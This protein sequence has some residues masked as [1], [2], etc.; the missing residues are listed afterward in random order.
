MNGKITSR[1]G[2]SP[3]LYVYLNYKITTPTS[4]YV[5]VYRIY[6]AFSLLLS[7]VN[8]FCNSIIYVSCINYVFG[9][10]IVNETKK[11]DP[12]LVPHTLTIPY[13]N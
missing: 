13:D 2:V 1:G 9:L 8:A 11:L 6:T 12:V 7:I 5:A 3:K 4:K 10:N